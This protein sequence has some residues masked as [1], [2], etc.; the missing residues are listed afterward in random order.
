M[1]TILPKI[2]FSAAKNKKDYTVIPANTPTLHP[3]IPTRMVIHPETNVSPRQDH[4]QPAKDAVK[5]VD[6][7]ATCT[8]RVTTSMC[9][10]SAKHL[11]DHQYIHYRRYDLSKS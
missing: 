3:S 10:P 6:R 11:C 4:S 5:F 1:A 8:G 2:Y 9:Y 7:R